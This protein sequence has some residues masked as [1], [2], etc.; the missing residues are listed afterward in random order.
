[1]KSFYLFIFYFLSIGLCLAQVGISTKDPTETLDVNGKMRVRVFE[2]SSY[3]QD[4]DLVVKGEI[5]NGKI[6]GVLRQDNTAIGSFMAYLKTDQNFTTPSPANA[7]Y[8]INNFEEVDNSGG[9]Y[10]SATGLFTPLLAGTYRF[11]I[12]ITL[13]VDVTG[14][15]EIGLVDGAS[16]GWITK[17]S[18]P[19]YGEKASNSVTFVGSVNLSSGQSVYFGV[20]GDVILLTHPTG[21]TGS[22]IGSYFEITY[23]KN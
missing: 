2:N 9:A 23:L 3:M 11:I 19:E 12:S 17:Y 4:L 15:C 18:V 10:N 5:E 14:N 6:D 7:I 8:K 20:T 13:S 22:G 16:N 21:N 1:M